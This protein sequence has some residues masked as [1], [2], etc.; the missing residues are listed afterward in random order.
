VN[1]ILF[2]MKYEKGEKLGEGTF[3]VVYSGFAIATVKGKPSKTKV[4]IKRIK[5]KDF[6]NGLDLSAIREIK[7]LSE[8]D[9]P[10]IIK[11]MDVFTINQ[12]LQLVLE[13][14]DADL[15]MLIKN[16]NIVFSSADIKSWMIM[17]LRGLFHCHS[18]DF[19]HR[20]LKP[21]NLL[22]ASNGELKIAD[23]GLARIMGDPRIPMTNQVVTRWYRAPEL[24]LGAKHY[25]F[26]VDIWATGCIFAELM[27]RT[28]Y[29][30]AETD[31]AQLNMIF[32]ALGTPT[33]K[34][35]PVT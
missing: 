6:Q 26:G 12:S 23:F 5:M 13:F 4:A 18:M 8:I 21:S 29:F 9:H 3:A 15:E 25:S 14:L 2:E 34:E 22:L 28:P 31:L 19:L 27:L 30:A 7:Y 10:N 24:L 17:L 32:Q 16:K 11:L 1:E 33:D 20:D 35:W